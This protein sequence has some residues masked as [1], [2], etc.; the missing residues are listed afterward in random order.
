MVKGC[1]EPRVWTTPQTR[2]E[3]SISFSTVLLGCPSMNPFGNW[4][5]MEEGREEREVWNL[6]EPIVCILGSTLQVV[7]PEIRSSHQNELMRQHTKYF[8]FSSPLAPTAWLD[9]WQAGG[10]GGWGGDWVGWVSQDRA[11]KINKWYCK[12][13]YNFVRRMLVA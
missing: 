4:E 1:E 10:W 5:G 3:P 7:C 11:F 12:E 6:K 9:W 13:K 8:N 2:E